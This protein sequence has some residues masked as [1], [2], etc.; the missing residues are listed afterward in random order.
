MPLV[1]IPLI[2]VA[3]QGDPAALQDGRRRAAGHARL[4]AAPDEPH[5]RRARRRRPP[6][7]ARGAR[8]RASRC[9]PNHLVAVSVVSDEEEQERLERQW[10]EF[11]IDV[12]LEIVYSPYR[13]LTRP[14]L[15]YIDEL[16]ARWENDI[17]TVRAPRVRRAPLV[18]QPPPQPERAAAQGPP[19]VPQGHGRDLGARTTSSEATGLGHRIAR[20]QIGLESTSRPLAFPSFSAPGVARRAIRAT[21][22]T[23]RRCTLR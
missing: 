20:R 13:E 4:Q 21:P 1:V 19:A 11:G 9:R 17:I 6:R 23:T 12:P 16:D 7:R 15:R 18:G 2:V 14:I 22:T 5:R 8:L 10:E 3:V